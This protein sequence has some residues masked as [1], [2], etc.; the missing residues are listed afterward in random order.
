YS[1]LWKGIRRFVKPRGRL[2]GLKLCSRGEAYVSEEGGLRVRRNHEHEG[3]LEAICN[4]NRCGASFVARRFSR[5][6]KRSFRPIDRVGA[7]G[8]LWSRGP[9]GKRITRADN[10]ARTFQRRF[11]TGL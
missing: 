8:N 4:C 6:G 5:L 3:A 1:Q 10:A 7:E 9:Y 11:R 2:P